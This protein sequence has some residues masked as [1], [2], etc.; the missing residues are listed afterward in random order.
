MRFAASIAPHPN[1]SSCEAQLPRPGIQT[2]TRARELVSTKLIEFG[3]RWPDKAKPSVPP[4]QRQHEQAAISLSS[5]SS[6]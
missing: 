1:S 4:E 6:R 5:E 3:A 2:D